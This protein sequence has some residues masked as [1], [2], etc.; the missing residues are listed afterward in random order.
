VVTWEDQ[1]EA[2]LRFLGNMFKIIALGTD[3]AI[4]RGLRHRRGLKYYEAVRVGGGKYV[5]GKE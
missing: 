4:T 5:A 3:W 1:L 2:D